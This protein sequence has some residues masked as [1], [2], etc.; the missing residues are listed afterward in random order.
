MIKRFLENCR[1]PRGLVGRLVAKGMNIGHTTI[2]KWGLSYLSPEKDARVLDIGCG[3]GANIGRLL[4]MCPDGRVSGIDYSEESVAI[5]RGKNASALER[6]DIRQGSVSALPYD[7]DTFD[8]VIAFETIY[9]WPNPETDFREVCRVLRPGGVF[10]ICNE[11]C[12]PSDDTWTSK[13]DGMRVYSKE[14]L[15][16]LLSEN[17]FDITSVNIHASGWLCLTAQKRKLTS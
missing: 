2:S 16:R 15:N 14:D 9:F 1:K 7:D 8:A 6:C 4:E 5:S 10:L 17:G 11:A 13:I 3:G 12:D